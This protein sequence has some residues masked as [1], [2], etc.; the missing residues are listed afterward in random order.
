MEAIAVGAHAGQQILFVVDVERRALRTCKLDHVDTADEQVPI[1]HFSR[2][3]QHCAQ[4]HGGA[5]VR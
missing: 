4:L 3:R 2:A 5:L 1:A